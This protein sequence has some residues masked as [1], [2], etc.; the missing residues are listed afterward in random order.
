MP[1]IYY[2]QAATPDER[3]MVLDHQR[4]REAVA[5]IAASAAVERAR[6]RADALL[7]DGLDALEALP[8]GEARDALR[9]MAYF[10]VH[11]R[12]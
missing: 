3:A 8:A 2:L 11:R 6:T 12:Q 5:A 9:E 1:V 4:V 10:V 7:A